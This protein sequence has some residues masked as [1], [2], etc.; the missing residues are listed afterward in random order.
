MYNLNDYYYELPPELIAQQP[1]VQR[2]QSKLLCLNRQNGRLKHTLFHR[3]G[4]FF[5]PGDV[6]VIN[7]TA[8]IP[9]RLAGR[10]ATGGK[11]DVLISDVAGMREPKNEDGSVV[12]RC[13]VKSSKRSL[14][15]TWYYFDHDLKA[16]VLDAENGSFRLKFHSKEDLETVLNRIGQV[17]LPP[18]VKRV[19]GENDNFN[20]SA[21]YQTVYA[22]QK[23][24]I[25]APTAGLHF[26]ADMLHQ[27]RDLGV[28]IVEL[29][30]HVGYGTFLPVR[31]A[32]IRLHKM[33]SESFSISAA[34]AEKINTARDNG[35]RVTAVGT[36]CV[37]TL[38][39]CANPNGEI[40]S[41][42]GDCDLFIYPGYQFK[43]VD[44]MIT[45]FHLPESTLLMLVSAFAG[46]RNM[47]NAYREAV[48]RQYRFFS[49]GDAM[50]IH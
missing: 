3:L 22:S 31:A 24:A 42:S 16:E 10:K 35:K 9:A 13:L 37:R 50:L 28:M 8:V 49:Y 39:Y 34:V 18:Y 36:T 26:T 17:P 48:R 41:G 12:C 15:G 32:D 27:L 33:H 21:A 5:E 11:V 47:L 44:A 1:V 20:D 38:E 2:D 30:L 23:G 25:A 40:V 4:D 6:L 46:R 29:T 43:V 19:Q 14:P 7:N 45:N